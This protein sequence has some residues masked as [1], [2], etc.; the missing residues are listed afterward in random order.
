MLLIPGVLTCVSATNYNFSRSQT[1]RV[2]EE[3][4]SRMLPKLVSVVI[5]CLWAGLNWC[6][7]SN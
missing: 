1:F 7:R 3:V 2:L 4:E 6:K 5:E